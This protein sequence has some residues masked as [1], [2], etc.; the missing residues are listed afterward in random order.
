MT[1]ASWL[2]IWPG[3]TLVILIVAFNLCGDACDALIGKKSA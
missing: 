3:L 1:F 2:V